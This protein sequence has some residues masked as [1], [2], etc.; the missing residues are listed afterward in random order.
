MNLEKSRAYFAPEQVEKEIHIIGV[1]AIGS[2]L[3]ENLVR[4][5]IKKLNIYDFDTVDDKNLANQWFYADQVNNSKENA[6][7]QQSCN[8]NPECIIVQHG[9]YEGQV[10]SG[11]VFLC[12]DSIELRQ[13]IVNYNKYNRN[14][15]A[16]FDCRM[17]ATDAQHY[18]TVWEPADI[19]VFASTMDFTDKEA[20]E[21]NPVNACGGEINVRYLVNAIVAFAVANFVSYVKNKKLKKLILVD[22]ESFDVIVM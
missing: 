7:H 10:L 12:V 22:L 16:M 8:I 20:K 4:L 19:E 3:V 13:H 1:G 18:A 2:T 11:Y 14:I 6:I 21:A 9:K 15:V 17:R 5:G